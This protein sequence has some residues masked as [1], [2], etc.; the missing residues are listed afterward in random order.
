MK[1][2]ELKS[3]LNAIDQDL[4]QKDYVCAFLLLN[5]LASHAV[6][7]GYKLE[8]EDLAIWNDGERRVGVMQEPIGSVFEKID[9]STVTI[10]DSTSLD[11]GKDSPHGG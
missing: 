1:I 10:G 8:V 6:R 5:D 9:D 7:C 2:D 4:M 3:C 11:L